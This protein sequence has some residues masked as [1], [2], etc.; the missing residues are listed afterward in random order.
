MVDFNCLRQ[1]QDNGRL[2]G[3]NGMIKNETVLHYKTEEEVRSNMWTRIPI[4][5]SSNVFERIK[6][7]G[8][9]EWDRYA[10]YLIGDY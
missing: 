3:D 1:D 2:D 6:Y 10:G 5:Q 4:L 8:W 9:D 7:F